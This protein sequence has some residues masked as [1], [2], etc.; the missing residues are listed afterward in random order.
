MYSDGKYLR[1]HEHSPP[2]PAPMG[3]T[4]MYWYYIQSE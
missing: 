1:A 4:A 3:A 2:P